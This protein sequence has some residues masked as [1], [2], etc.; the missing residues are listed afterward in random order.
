M[1]KEY[2]VRVTALDPPYNF[3]DNSFH[4]AFVVVHVPHDGFKLVLPSVPN[5]IGTPMSMGRAP[6]FH[7]DASCTLNQ[8]LSISNFPVNFELRHPVAELTM[9]NRVVSQNVA[10]LHHPF[11]SLESMLSRQVKRSSVVGV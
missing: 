2:R 3:L 4:R 8:L 6:V 7:S 11:H 9:R 1:E 10:I 5:G